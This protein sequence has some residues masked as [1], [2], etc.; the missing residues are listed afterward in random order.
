M[1]DIVINESPIR[2]IGEYDA[3][4]VPTNCYQTMRNGFQY[5]VSRK[6]PHVLEW[7]YR[8]KYGDPSKLG[9]ILECKEE[10][11]PLFVLMFTTFGYN[12]KG[13]ERDYFDYDALEKC[14]KLVNILYEGRHLATTMI[15]CTSFEG[16]ADKE[17]I[18]D[19]VN[20]QITNL[21]LTM[22]DYRQ[23]PGDTI[24]QREYTNSRKR[25][26]EEKKKSGQLARKVRKKK[27]L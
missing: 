8:T 24:R 10:G 7:N 17:M 26:Y 18:L 4:L 2:H 19:I 27:R 6:Y 11:K 16:N 9:D 3:I 21:D 15:G 25:L 23:E 22:Y 14:L 13:I 12:F 5:E 1:I 20:K